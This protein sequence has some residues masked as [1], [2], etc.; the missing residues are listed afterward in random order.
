MEANPG[1]VWSGIHS[2]HDDTRLR[3]ASAW[4]AAP[5]REHVPTRQGRCY[6]GNEVVEA[7]CPQPHILGP[8][9]AREDTRPYK[10]I[11]LS[12]AAMLG[13]P[14]ARGDTRPYTIARSRE[15]TCLYVLRAVDIN[16]LAL[17]RPIFRAVHQARANWIF[18]D[19]FPFL[20]VT[21]I[22]A[23]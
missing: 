15:D 18:A 17:I 14:P 22:V 3:G 9:S 12:S 11:T 10:V 4:Q 2:R 23:P 16:D 7:A 1:T 19:V 6:P 13:P 20:C 8:A 21:F 5:W